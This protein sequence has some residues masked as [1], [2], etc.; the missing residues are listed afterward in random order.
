MDLG[1]VEEG[2]GDRMAGGTVVDATGGDCLLHDWIIR[3][4]RKHGGRAIP[5]G[6]ALAA[7]E[8]PES[9][10][11]LAN[12]E[13]TD[14]HWPHKRLDGP[15]QA[16]QVLQH[17]TFEDLGVVPIR[18]GERLRNGGAEHRVFA[19][20]APIVEEHPTE[21]VAR[22]FDIDGKIG[23]ANRR[24]QFGV[25]EVRNGGE[26]GGAPLPTGKRKG[27]V[28]GLNLLRRKQDC[29]GRSYED[30]SEG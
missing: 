21:G 5:A 22:L 9:T 29:R 3:R 14:R 10:G 1:P 4:K 12:E 26:R 11:T 13:A 28:L 19:G 27:I 8:R 7:A 18:G 15:D 17:P 30:T 24:R 16:G 23:L 6:K 20:G 25:V 2:A